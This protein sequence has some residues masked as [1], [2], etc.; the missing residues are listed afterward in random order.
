MQYHGAIGGEDIEGARGGAC[1]VDFPTTEGPWLAP[2]TEA[3][4]S[5]DRVHR[6]VVHTVRNGNYRCADSF[7]HHAV[8]SPFHSS[9]TT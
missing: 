9:V 8:A 4:S 1:V 6:C 5:M 2:P 3:E 7:F